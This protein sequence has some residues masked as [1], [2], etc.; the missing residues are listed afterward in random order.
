[1]SLWASS[2]EV[3]GLQS[4]LGTGVGEW[5]DLA[6]ECCPRLAVSLGSQGTRAS[7]TAW[8]CLCHLEQVRDTP[9]ALVSS[10]AGLNR[11]VVMAKVRYNVKGH[12]LAL[13]L[14]GF[15]TELLL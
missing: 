7:W 11:V 14:G 3:T 2:L 13:C 9:G 6:R 10:P 5:G 8:S 12:H 15:I 1:M 4:S